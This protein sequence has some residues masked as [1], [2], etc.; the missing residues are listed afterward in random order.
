MDGGQ[1]WTPLQLAVLRVLWE[2]GE[3]SV[4]DVHAALLDERGLAPTTVATV[5]AR[6]AKQGAVARRTEGRAY[7]YRARLSEED[8]RRRM[9]GELTERLF[10]GDLSRLV[11][12]LLD[13]HDVDAGE[14]ERMRRMIEE[15][16]RRGSE[17]ESDGS[18]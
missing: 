1:Q 17:E 15:R 14:L 7:L 16:A 4:N 5:L 2:R 9:V 8:A 6:L 18:R 3:A 10:E 12:H 13:A 11:S